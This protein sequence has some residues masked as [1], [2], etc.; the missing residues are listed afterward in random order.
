[1]LTGLDNLHVFENLEALSL[2]GA[3][4]LLR[5]ANHNLDASNRFNI[6]LAGGTT[7]QRLY[8][9]LAQTS[10][11]ELT[12]WSRWHVFFGDERCVPQDDPESNYRMA[13]E[14]LLDRVPI[15]GD[16]IHPMVTDPG[17]PEGEASA[18]E[19]LIRH[20]VA[21]EN[22]EPVLDLVLLGL[23]ADG[24]TASLFPD[25]AILE[26]R[27]RLVAPVYVE[28]L[29]STRIS[30]TYPLLDHARHILF[31]VAGETKGTLIAAL[32][33]GGDEPIYPVQTLAPQGTVEWYIDRAAAS[34][35]P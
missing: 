6:A 27:D 10:L 4:Q 33:R 23:G 18:Y 7:P 1:M 35:L 31:L 13:R 9:L 28:Q 24:H 12:D 16:Q 20:E 21:S 11:R 25:T 3:E 17:Y 2:A 5:I 19:A 22:A 32:E 29:G 26:V 34:R 30:F 8:R 15:P 14:A